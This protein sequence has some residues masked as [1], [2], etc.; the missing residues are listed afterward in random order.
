MDGELAISASVKIHWL[1]SSDAILKGEEVITASRCVLVG[2]DSLESRGGDGT[3]G[4]TLDL[5]RVVEGGWDRPAFEG[6]S[7]VKRCGGLIRSTVVMD[8]DGWKD[9]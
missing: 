2:G 1:E 4:G 6:A 9:A 7:E 3:A 8:E 5:A